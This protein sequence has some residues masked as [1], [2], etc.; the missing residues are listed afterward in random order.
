MSHN[1]KIALPA[2]CPQQVPS[3]PNTD[4]LCSKLEEKPENHVKYSTRSNSVD[5]VEDRSYPR[6][7]Q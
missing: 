5:I 7:R 2:L 4:T 3:Q 6:L 1:Q